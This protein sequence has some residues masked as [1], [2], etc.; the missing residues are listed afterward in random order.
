[1]S[2]KEKDRLW[3]IEVENEAHLMKALKDIQGQN[4]L[5]INYQRRKCYEG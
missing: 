5:G 2:S 1:M 3:I 4:D